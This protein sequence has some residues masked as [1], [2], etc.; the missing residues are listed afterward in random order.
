MNALIL[1]LLLAQSSLYDRGGE[2]LRSG[3]LAEAEQ[4][5]R[6]HLK[7]NPNHV[8]AHANLGSV[9]SRREDFAGAITQYR[10]A[11]ALQPGLAPLRLNLGIAYFKAR[12]WGQAVTQFDAFLKAQPGHRQSMQLRALSLLELEQYTEAALAFEALLPGDASVQLG[13]ATAYLRSDRV[14]QAQKLLG[15]LLAQNNSP[16]VLL[17]VGQ[18]LFA[19]DRL[20]EALETL[21]KARQLSP[22]L[23][24]LALNLGAVHWKQKRTAE[25]VAE[26]RNELNLHPDSA[27][28]KF[29]LG[30]AVAMSGG[31]KI[32][33]ER[34]LR[35]S[36]AQKPRHARANYQLA[37]LVWQTKRSPEAV[38]CLEK[39]IAATPDYREAYYLLGTIHQS[40][41]RKAEAA[42]AFAA[43]KRLSAKELATQQDLFSE[44]Q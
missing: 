3:K 11:L 40:L 15:P 9:L 4:A 24:T 16:E 19:E 26:W 23:P 8:E 33:A 17:T 14:A 20:D 25:A 13:L 38:S 21:L 43:V 31:D 7:A 12:N 1:I 29:T 28:A 18:A 5:Y 34:L 30:A 2:L 10:K 44:Q 36:L 32:E 39:S 6:A 35:T 27:E 37:K 41:G 22:N 42:K